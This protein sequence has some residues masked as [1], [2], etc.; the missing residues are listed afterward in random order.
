MFGSTVMG[1]DGTLCEEAMA[2]LKQA[3]GA[4]DDLGLDAADLAGLVETFKE[5][6]RQETG[7]AFPQSPAEQLQRAVLA[8]FQSWNAERARLYRRREH[9]PDGLGTAVNVQTMVFGNLGADSGSG[10]AF[11]R[12]PATG[13]SGVYGDYLA[14]AQ[15]EDVVAGIRNTLPLDELGRLNPEAFG[16]LSDHRSEE[17][18]VGKG[19]NCRGG[20]HTWHV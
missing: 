3:R 17:R 12:D 2:R 8:V 14:N 11:T 6:I 5:L 20:A 4:T 19:D 15:G 18:R 9:I 13:R 10:V 1:V 7:E 16:Q